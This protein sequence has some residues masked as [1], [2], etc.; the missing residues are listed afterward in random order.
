MNRAPGS[1][2]FTLIE[3]LV[4]I[5]IIAILAAILFPVFAQAREAARKTTCLNN[6]KQIGT[7]HIMYAQDYDEVLCPSYTNA[8][9]PPG[10]RPPATEPI[11]AS[12]FGWAD[13]INPYTKN[14]GI[15]TCPSNQVNKMRLRTDI[16]PNRFY[17][18]PGGAAVGTDAA[19]GARPVDA[20]YSYGMNEFSDTGLE[21][22]F[23]FAYRAL[24]SIP[25][26]AGTAGIAEGRGNSPCSIRGSGGAV[27]AGV[28]AQVDGRRHTHK[29]ILVGGRPDTFATVMFIDGHSKFTSLSQSVL[30]PNVWTARD[31][32]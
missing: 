32:D 8:M 20:D 17:R 6:L 29:Q 12:A 21:G 23:D 25:S 28:E 26:P 16:T 15:F 2:G 18:W 10:T 19:G 5:A 1:R 4:V 3:L 22:P 27:F 7:A 13:L 11:H 31:D 24:A 14:M 30:R 9:V